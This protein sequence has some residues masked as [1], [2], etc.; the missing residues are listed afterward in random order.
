MITIL[1]GGGAFFWGGEASTPP[2]RRPAEAAKKCIKKCDT[3]A[4]LL[5]CLLNLFFSEILFAIETS[6]HKDPL[7]T[8]HD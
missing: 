4:N 5:F 6:D 3:H 7:D 1:G 8:R 2:K